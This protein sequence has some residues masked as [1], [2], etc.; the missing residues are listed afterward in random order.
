MMV[1]L[2]QPASTPT[3]RQIMYSTVATHDSGRAPVQALAVHVYL[4]VPIKGAKASRNV[5]PAAPEPAHDQEL[6]LPV[7][8]IRVSSTVAGYAFHA[9][10]HAGHPKLGLARLLGAAASPALQNV[11]AHM[12]RFIRRA[13]TLWPP[14]QAKES[15]AEVI[16]LWLVICFPWQ[17]ADPTHR[18]AS[19]AT[20]GTWHHVACLAAYT[21][22]SG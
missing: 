5:P 13:L 22:T 7:E 17:Y 12:Y 14:G 2:F 16:E 21:M 9:P 4:K 20:Q 19:L 10:V 3:E 11:S 6:W 18:C 15:L 8:S 1:L